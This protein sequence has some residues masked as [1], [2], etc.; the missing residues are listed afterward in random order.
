MSDAIHPFRIAIPDADLDDL[1]RRLRA[2]RWPDR[3]TVG[4]WSQGVPLAYVQAVCDTWANDFDWRAWE[5]KLNAWPQFTTTIAGVDI[6]F[7]H[8]R[9]PHEGARPLIL[10]HGWPGS[11]VEFHKVIDPLVN[12]TAH[13]GRAEDAFHIVAPSL[14]GY[15]F[16]GKPTARGWGV[17][18]IADAWATLMARL[19]YTRY[20]AQGGD[21]GSA[22]TGCIGAQD[23]EHCAG[24]HLNMVVARPKDT[25]AAQLTPQETAALQ[26]LRHYQT[27]DSAYA[28]QMATRP[29]T[30][31]YGLADS[32][33]GQCGWILEKYWS[34]TDCGGAP[35][36]VLSRDE[37]L[38]NIAIYW[39]TNSAASSGRLY[40]HSF[41]RR[42]QPPVHVP[43]GG[44]IYPKEIFRASRRWAEE[45]FSNI[46]HW[47]E[48]PVGGHFAAFEQPGLFVA[49]LRECFGR[50]AL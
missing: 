21:W 46:V 39:L 30:L 45:R 40:W 15:G 31:G 32:P 48:H 41:G 16:S 34:W 6:H 26:A 33:A 38:A 14:P 36:T 8:V 43:M 3:E 37:M 12:P 18:K 5:A 22:V 10:T 9:S 11:Q 19:G 7:F 44:A 4:D 35:E 29:Q 17:E 24:I 1:Q 49:D 2:T 23:A 13:G 47:A 28:R 50:M 42:E 20:F 27:I 25:D